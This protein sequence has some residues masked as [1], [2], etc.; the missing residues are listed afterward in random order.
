MAMPTMP[1]VDEI[2]ARIVSDIETAIGQTTPFLPKSWNRVV[3]KAIAL[4]DILL[5]R[6]IMWVYAQIFPDT[7]DSAALVLLGA[8]VGIAPTKPIVA[9]IT[10]NIF[11][12]NGESVATGTNFRS[13]TGTVYQVTT[14]ATISGGSAPCSL[15]CQVSC[16]I[17]NI[18]NGETLTIV[19]PDTALTGLATVSGATTLGSDAETVDHFRARVISRYKKRLTGGS[20]AD[21]EQW[22]LETPHFVWISPVAGNEPGTVWVYGEVD[23]QVDGIPTSTQLTSL[24]SYLTVDPSTGLES[25]RPIGDEIT[26]M[27]ISRKIFDFEITIK[28]GSS[29]AKTDAESALSDYLLS[30]APYNEAINSERDDAVTDTGANAAVNDIARTGGATILQLVMRERDTGSQVNSYM[31]Y[32]GEKAKIGTVSWIDFI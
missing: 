7:A 10:A 16:D 4:I 12:T 29:A 21:Y 22:G 3:A 8:L 14:G 6:S 2:Q 15:T 18:A 5:Y 25:R 28:D 24:L 30:L 1:T 23:N 11:G 32:G 13:A 9:V 19:S 26:C 31:L 20:P 27:P 17:G